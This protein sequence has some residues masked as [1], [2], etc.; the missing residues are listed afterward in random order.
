[1]HVYISVN[2]T[3]IQVSKGSFPLVAKVNLQARCENF[4]PVTIFKSTHASLRVGFCDESERGFTRDST[5]KL[6]WQTTSSPQVE[7]EAL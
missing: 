6:A 5:L 2:Q 7:P 3:T 1:M 4:H